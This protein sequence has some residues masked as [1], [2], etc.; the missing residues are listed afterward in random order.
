VPKRSPRGRRCQFFLDKNAE[1][2]AEGHIKVKVKSSNVITSYCK[3]K[4][5]E[6]NTST[7][8]Q[9]KKL[10]AS[11]TKQHSVHAQNLIL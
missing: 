1:T 6:V 9:S 4:L 2:E 3:Q 11:I 8:K 10:K 7:L 5:S